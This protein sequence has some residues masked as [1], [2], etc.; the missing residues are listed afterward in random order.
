MKKTFTPFIAIFVLCCLCVMNSCT[1]AILD[2]KE[3]TP[4]LD[5]PNA[6]DSLKIGLIAYYPFNNSSAD[7]SGNNYNGTAYNTVVTN[8]RNGKANSAYYFNGTN[9]YVQVADNK[10]LRL[11]ATDFTINQWVKVSSYN[12]TYGSIILGKRGVG[13][14]NGWSYGI[15]GLMQSNSTVAGQITFQVSGGNDPFAASVKLVNLNSWYM[16]TTVYSV[17]KQQLTYY[18]NGVLDAVVSNIPSPSVFATSDMFIGTDN[19]LIGQSYF[20]MGYLDDMRIYNRALP[21]SQILKLAT[22]TY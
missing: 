4:N 15:H 3:E 17:Q 19:P 2:N 14:S 7:E 8:D 11:N 1:K 22:V 6:V 20:F 5:N 16:L 9:S 21:V 10:A 18:I 13:N 12:G